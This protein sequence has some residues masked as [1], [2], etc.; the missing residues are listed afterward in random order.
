MFI[1]RTLYVPRHIRKSDSEV[2]EWKDGIPLVLEHKMVS[3]A[4]G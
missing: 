3:S 4:A 1:Y 2:A